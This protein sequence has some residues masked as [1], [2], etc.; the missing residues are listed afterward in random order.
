M[1]AASELAPNP[2]TTRPATAPGV[3]LKNATVLSRTQKHRTR[4]RTGASPISDQTSRTCETDHLAPRVPDR[5]CRGRETARQRIHGRPRSRARWSDCCSTPGAVI[6]ARWLLYRLSSSA[7][8]DESA[9]PATRLGQS[10]VDADYCCSADAGGSRT[11]AAHRGGATLLL[12]AR[13]HRVAPLARAGF[14]IAGRMQRCRV[15]GTG[16]C[17]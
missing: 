5:R 17:V 6:S 4:P 10:R 16:R 11:T 1:E 9:A 12:S 15:S 8:P 2:P 13:P 7:E 14:R 3:G